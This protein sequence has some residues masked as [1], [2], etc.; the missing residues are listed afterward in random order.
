MNIYNSEILNRLL[1]TAFTPTCTF[2]SDISAR[3]KNN[4]VLASISILE[5]LISRLCET[6][7]PFEF[8][9][10]EAGANGAPQDANKSLSLSLSS[11][12]AAYLYPVHEP[13]PPSPPSEEQ[14]NGSK[15]SSQRGFVYT[16]LSPRGALC[17][18]NFQY[19]FGVDVLF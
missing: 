17:Q 16:K 6:V 4:I 12:L 10:T 7:N 9:N 8:S 19:L 3:T 14:K 13:L 1:E 18:R 15:I 5:S 2:P 11:L